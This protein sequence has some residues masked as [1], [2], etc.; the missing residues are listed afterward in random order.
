MSAD[1][2]A[3]ERYL[4]LLLANSDAVERRDV[5]AA[6][7]FFR[8]QFPGLAASAP[9]LRELHI[10]TRPGE[11]EI[12]RIWRL[13]TEVAHDPSIANLLTQLGSPVWEEFAAATET[14][15][16]AAGVRRAGGAA[17]LVA[18][19]PPAKVPD[20][21][22]EVAGREISIECTGLH[23]PEA[24]LRARYLDEVMEH[25]A[26]DAGYG[27]HFMFLLDLHR[28]SLDMAEAAIKD[29][30]Q[31]ISRLA[32]A[33]VE[34]VDDSIAGVSIHCIPRAGWRTVV[35]EKLPYWDAYRDASRRLDAR[36]LLVRIFQK[37][38]QLAGRDATLLT[39]RNHHLFG[40]T[41]SR[42]LVSRVAAMI[43]R[44]LAHAP[45]IG[46]VLD[47]EEWIDGRNEAPRELVGPHYRAVIGSIGNGVSRVALLVPNP[48]AA[49]PLMPDEQIFMSKVL[50]VTS[51]RDKAAT[52]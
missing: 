13:I 8:T 44:R 52:I 37:R 49:T 34:A 26:V 14:L 2:S 33:G 31:A 25:W 9:L 29:I 1:W 32:N 38:A 10:C 45:E 12:V 11:F 47:Y 41:A 39:I 51:K 43:A 24:E 28:L 23:E 20:L 17:R 36:R 46:A 30:Q 7:A 6:L 27:G 15:E 5:I 19:A 48:R 42:R 21:I 22:A 4:E 16:V 3:V 50:F 35:L 18:P 40:G